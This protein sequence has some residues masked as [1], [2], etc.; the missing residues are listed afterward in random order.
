MEVEVTACWEAGGSLL[1]GRWQ[2]VGVKVVACG[3]GSGSLLG[4]RWL[5]PWGVWPRL[6]A[7]CYG[8]SGLGPLRMA[9]EW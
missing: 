6:L 3:G 1:G 7:L 9:H 4:W 2:L 5:A 8:A